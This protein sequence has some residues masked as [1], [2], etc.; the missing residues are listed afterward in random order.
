M[1]QRVCLSTLKAKSRIDTA[2]GIQERNLRRGIRKLDSA[3]SQLLLNDPLHG[4]R[5]LGE[6]GLKWFQGLVPGQ[7]LD[8]DLRLGLCGR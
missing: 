8:A 6:S 1:A 2:R 4:E 5:Q 3:R 7:G